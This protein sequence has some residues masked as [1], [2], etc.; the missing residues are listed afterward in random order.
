MP[1]RITIPNVPDALHRLLKVRAARSGMS[2]SVYLLRELQELAARPTIEEMRLRLT[3]HS[4]VSPAVS[5]AEAVRA[6]R[7]SGSRA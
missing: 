1:S 6:V 7:D 3:R 2:L 4:A 5:P